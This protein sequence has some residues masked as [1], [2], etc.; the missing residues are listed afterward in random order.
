MMIDALRF[1]F[2]VAGVLCAGSLAALVACSSDNKSDAGP[3]CAMSGGAVTGPQ[4]NHCG[5]MVQPTSM[6][7]CH[8]DV[9]VGG[10]DGGGGGDAG[11]GDDAGAVDAGD[12]GNCGNDA[13]GPTMYNQSGADDDCKYDVSWTS[14]PVCVGVPVTFTVKA[15]NRTDHSPLTG[16][17]P[18]WDVGLQCNH[19]SPTVAT[20]GTE[21][22]PGTYTLPPVV[23]D[24]SGKWVVRF[25]FYEN[26]EDLLP[27]SPHGHAAFW[28]QVP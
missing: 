26:C 27:T 20:D 22:S 25:H 3:S 12:I 4:D 23:F 5:T 6:T 16:A 11:G 17:A 8:P 10:D 14:T 9:A 24:K 21:T 13:Y 18:Q 28:L 19:V 15:T 1:G 7:S 2:R